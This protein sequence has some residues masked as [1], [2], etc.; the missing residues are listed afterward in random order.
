VRVICDADDRPSGLVGVSSD[1]SDR[2][3]SERA[4]RAAHESARAVA[5]GMAESL[6]TID[7][8]GRVTYANRAAE[9]LLGWSNEELRGQLAHNLVHSRHA[10]GSPYPIE[11]CPITRAGVL[12]GPMRVDEDVFIR[13]DGQPLPVA[14]TASP[15]QTEAGVQGCAVVF[16]DITEQKA[17]EASMRRDAETLALV[18]RIQDALDEG[19]F[20]LHSQ[21]IIDLRSGEVVQQELLLRMTERDGEIVAP[22]VFLP[23]AERYGL[24]DDI[25]RWVIAAAV[26]IAAEG[27]PVQVNLSARSL[28]DPSILQQIESSI[29]ATGAD[30]ELLVFEITETAIAD[31]ETAA[32][33]FAQRLH[34]LGCKL[35]LDDFGTG[36][37]AFTYLKQLPV[38]YLKID[39]EFIRDL[40]E[41]AASR[42]LVNAVIALARN[43][44]LQTIAEGVEDSA[45][46]K[47]LSTLGVDF[48]QGYHIARPGPIQRVP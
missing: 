43:F 24:I 1:I 18:S 37:G 44:G 28:G 32:R 17:R 5:D 11:E 45:T 29:A 47:L 9:E 15:F 6:Y 25:D 34:Q 14:Y 8:E 7:N 41:S 12:G 26:K 27:D 39:I 23:I 40:V 3:A 20:V 38:D 16:R 35:A 2:V 46:L 33:A 4:L 48:A 13:R 30:P 10:D 36:Y 42:H 22:A 21:P 19:R 31:D